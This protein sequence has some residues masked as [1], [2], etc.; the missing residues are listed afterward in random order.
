MVPGFDGNSILD[1][2]T[3]VVGSG[4]SARGAQR[5]TPRSLRPLHR[6]PLFDPDASSHVEPLPGCLV[7]VHRPG[8]R[9]AVQLVR[10]PRSPGLPH[11]ADYGEPDVA[12][13][14]ASLAPTLGD[15]E[16]ALRPPG[17]PRGR[18]DS[19]RLFLT[20][21]IGLVVYPIAR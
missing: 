19:G 7:K 5:V 15:M 16:H 11:P 8:G 21:A 2:R 18:R 9:R 1:S 10:S 3:L 14:L 6:R 17:E 4:L 20:V 12:A 13:A